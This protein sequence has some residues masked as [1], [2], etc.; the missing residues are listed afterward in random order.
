MAVE[1]T[2]TVEGAENLQQALQRLDDAAQR[3]IQ[4]HLERWAME[5]REHARALAPVRTG[6]LR[7]SIYTKTSGW[8]VKVGASAEYAIYVEF[9]TR[10]MQAKPFLRPAVEEHLPTLE[11]AIL[12]ALE[13]SKTE[14]G[15]P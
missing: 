10:H 13:K 15:L 12:E 8:T 6:L 1:I 9:G 2:I 7:N 5:V 14:A 4:E 11:N 3:N